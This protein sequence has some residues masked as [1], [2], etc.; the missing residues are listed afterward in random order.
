MAR[1][2]DPGLLEVMDDLYVPVSVY[3]VYFRVHQTVFTGHIL[4]E[5][6]APRPTNSCRLQMA[7]IKK[8]GDEVTKISKYQN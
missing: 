1:R 7:A 8:I 6:V 2:G 5:V 3:F 4:S